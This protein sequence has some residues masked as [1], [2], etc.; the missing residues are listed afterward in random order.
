LDE[1]ISLFA[2]LFLVCFS[3]GKKFNLA[4][5]TPSLRKKKKL[6]L[7]YENN[8]SFALEKLEAGGEGIYEIDADKV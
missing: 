8:R 5:E 7:T 4:R 3:L 2:F 6:P 1:W